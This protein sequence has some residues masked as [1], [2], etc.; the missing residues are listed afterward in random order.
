M[1]DLAMPTM[2]GFEV[3]TRIRRSGPDGAM[4][5]AVARTA[6]ASE[7]NR[8]AVLAGRFDEHIAKPFKFPDL[9]RAVA[10]AVI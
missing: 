1:C 2:D 9:G 4:C 5:R 10:G 7:A 3:I 8:Q 6:L